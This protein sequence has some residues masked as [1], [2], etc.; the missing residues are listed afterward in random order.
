L[1]LVALDLIQLLTQLTELRLVVL[2][3]EHYKR[4]LEDK[5]ETIH[6]TQMA[7]LELE[8]VKEI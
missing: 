8:A 5:V 7:D 3:L 4:Q 6:L 1:V 2:L